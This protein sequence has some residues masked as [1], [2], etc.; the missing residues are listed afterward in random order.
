MH[1]VASYVCFFH[2]WNLHAVMGHL[3]HFVPI[4]R[5]EK[6][7]VYSISYNVSNGKYYTYCSCGIASSVSNSISY[8]FGGGLPAEPNGN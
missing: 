7:A 2:L 8:C 1:N 3:R 6:F 4:Y 5:E